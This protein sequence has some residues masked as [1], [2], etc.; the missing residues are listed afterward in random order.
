M[1]K[2]KTFRALSEKNSKSWQERLIE[3]NGNTKDSQ[4][5]SLRK[6]KYSDIKNRMLTLNY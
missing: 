1:P 5:S 2:N 6:K 3:S 4:M